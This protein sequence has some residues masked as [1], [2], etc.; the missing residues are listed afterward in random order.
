MAN[1]FVH[2]ELYTP[3]LGKAKDFYATLFDWKLEDIPMPEGGAY[4]M[5]KVGDG[6]GG[7]MMKVPEP[8][9]PPFWLAY[10]G[11]EDIAAAT[12]KARSLGAIV[13]KEVSEVGSYGKMSIIIDPTGAMLALWQPNPM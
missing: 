7:G 2:V 10:V 5:I 13:H 11:V 4:T 6:T 8:D 9:M 3:N 1:P 12:D